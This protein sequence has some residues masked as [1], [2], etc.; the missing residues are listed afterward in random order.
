MPVETFSVY[1]FGH[2]FLFD[3]RAHQHQKKMPSTGFIF[4][5][6]KLVRLCVID[7]AKLLCI[8]LQLFYILTNFIIINFAIMKVNLHFHHDLNSADLLIII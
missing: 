5:I 6:V 2:A 8:V 4:D 3:F 7:H 1:I